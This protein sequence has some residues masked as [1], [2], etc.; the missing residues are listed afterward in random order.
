M[1]NPLEAHVVESAA[2]P[3]AEMVVVR[4]DVRVV[5]YRPEALNG[6]QEAGAYKL[7]ERIVYGGS[8]QLG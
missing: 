4:V 3:A 7:S 8:R 1:F 6:L 5:A 2:T